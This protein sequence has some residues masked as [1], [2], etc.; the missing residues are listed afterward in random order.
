MKEIIFGNRMF[1]FYMI[2]QL[3]SGLGNGMF[4]F[5]MLISVHLLYGNPMFTGFAAFLFGAPSIVAFTV[6][7]MVDANNK[8]KIMRVTS[9]IEFAVLAVLVVLAYNGQIPAFIMFAVI[10]CFSIAALFE[11]AS[12]GAFLRQIVPGDKLIEANAVIS[13]VSIVGGLGVAAAMFPMVAEDRVDFT[14]I[15]GL[16]M[17]FVALAFL[18]SLF[19]RDTDIYNSTKTI[20]RSYIA[21]L[22]AGAVFLKHSVLMFFLIGT[23]IRFF[24]MDVVSVNLPAFVEY[25]WGARGYILLSVTSMIG[26]LF[27]SVIIGR[28]GK[29]IRIGPLM[30]VLMVLTGAVR[31]VF[32]YMLP[33][34]F[35]GSQG[36]HIIF[37]AIG[38]A[39]GIVSGAMWQ[40]LPPKNMVARVGTLSTTLTSISAGLGALFGGWLG[41]IINETEK[42]IMAQGF[43]YIATGTLLIIIPRVRHLPKINELTDWE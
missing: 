39:M 42:L 1:R 30:F 28:F 5:F 32:A 29:H 2:Y 3:F 41:H 9:L 11:R 34:N 23:I 12:N 14:L 6:G 43:I 20:S 26:G 33:T 27:A 17:V 7:P 4:G 31:I 22:K 38:A 25:Y 15:F 19:L 18:S 13:I 8:V 10:L 35:I 37:S 36:I 40:K 21:D 24:V 16:S